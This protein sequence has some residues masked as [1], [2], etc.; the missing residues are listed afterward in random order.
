MADEVTDLSNHEQFVVCLRWVDENTFDVSEDLIGLYQVDDITAATLFS[1]LKD[2]LL[3]LN[4]SIH[5]CRSQCFDGTS[6]MVGI[7]SGVATLICKEEPRAILVHCYG[8]SLQLAVGDTVK[9]IKTMSDAL[10]TT[11]EISKLLKYSPKRDTLFE[12]LK[13]ELAPDVPG[14]RVLCP[15]RWTVRADSLQS[16]IDNWEPLQELWDEC[17]CMPKLD[18]ELVSYHWC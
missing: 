17:L 14:F 9:E 5:N 7:R 4:L 15:T 1:S 13:K 18:S 2:V 8:H 6:N 10:D 16:I 11:N 3:R 12:K